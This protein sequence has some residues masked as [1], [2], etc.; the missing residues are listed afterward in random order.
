MY[1]DFKSKGNLLVVELSGELDH[2]SAQE[3]RVKVDDRLDR[4]NVKKLIFDFS[5]VT[6]MDSS[7][8]GVIIGRY[9]K[10]S[11]REGRVVIAGVSGSIKRIFDLSGIFKVIK[12]YSSVDEALKNI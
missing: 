12:V 3:V 8:I 5:E 1:L 4:F 7:G 2:H 11:V 10:L 6:F 9:K